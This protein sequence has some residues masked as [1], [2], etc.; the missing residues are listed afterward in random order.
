[1]VSA[2]NI[3][4]FESLDTYAILLFRAGMV[5]MYIYYMYVA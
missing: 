4:A 3:A 1:M 5:T 2:F